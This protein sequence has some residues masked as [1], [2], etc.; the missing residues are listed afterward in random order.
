MVGRSS[1]AGGLQ[2]AG[3]MYAVL[4]LCAGSVVSRL[5][6]LIQLLGTPRRKHYVDSAKAFES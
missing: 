4:A 6:A 3:A 5:F 2:H 1:S